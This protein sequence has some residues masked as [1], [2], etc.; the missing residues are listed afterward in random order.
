[1]Q[2]DA[3]SPSGAVQRM[4]NYINRLPAVLDDIN[5]RIDK[6]NKNVASMLEQAKLPFQ[7]A[8]DLE[9]AREEHKT[10][11]RAL[12][13]KGPEVPESQKSEVAKGIEQQKVK[14]RELGF[15]EALDE[16]Y[17]ATNKSD[18]PLLLMGK[19]NGGNVSISVA[20]SVVRRVV[21]ANKKNWNVVVL[22]VA[23]FD[24]LP[25]DVKSNIRKNYNEEAGQN[26]KGLIHRGKVYVIAGNNE[27]KADVEHTILHEIEG[28]FGIHKL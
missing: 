19:A 21:A 24:D 10:V 4:K 12:M 23:T 2:N 20:R 27:S 1:M 6:A 17:S 22:T 11:Q 28:H 5:H 9:R 8:G 7:H 15:G 25:D 14:L 13:A 26:A 16:F 3:F 18:I